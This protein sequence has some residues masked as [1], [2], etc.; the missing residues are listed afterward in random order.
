MAQVGGKRRART[1]S[2]SRTVGERLHHLVERAP[3]LIYCCDAGGLFTYVNPATGRAL[4]RD[5]E[6]LI[7][8]PLQTIVR[9]DYREAVAGQLARQLAERID[10]LYFEFPAIT[11]PGGTVWVGQHAQLLLAN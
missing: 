10:S 1:S 2:P 5:P 11:Q 8:Q 6:E 7:G 4:Q 3:D 9:P